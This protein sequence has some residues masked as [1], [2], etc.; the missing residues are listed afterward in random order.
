MPPVAVTA[1]TTAALSAA[2]L[3]DAAFAASAVLRGPN[4]TLVPTTLLTGNP[5]DDITKFSEIVA[6]DD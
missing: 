4:S 6:L 3:L 2:W 1:S 5:S